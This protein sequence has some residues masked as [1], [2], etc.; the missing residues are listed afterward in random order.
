MK[1][2]KNFLFLIMCFGAIFC[3]ISCDTLSGDKNTTDEDDKSVVE[4]I[5]YTNYLSDFSIKVKNNTSKKLVAFKGSPSAT[6]LLGGIPAG[7]GNEH[8]LK[9]DT[10]LFTTSSDFVLFIVTEEDYVK[11]QWHTY[12]QTIPVLL[13]QE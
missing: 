5:D 3:L 2:F 13:V 10:T 11:H 6:N 7:P 9:K 8:G 4:K 12:P 1:I